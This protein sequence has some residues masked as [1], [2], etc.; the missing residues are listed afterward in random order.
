M[1]RRSE[2]DKDIAYLGM[3]GGFSSSQRGLKWAIPLSPGRIARIEGI[4][5][6]A[7]VSR[8]ISHA[9]LERLIGE[10]N[11]AATYIRDRFPKSTLRPIYRELPPP[12]LISA[13]ALSKFTQFGAV[14]DNVAVYPAQNSA[15]AI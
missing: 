7:I 4:L 1:G 6:V 9:S 3:I 14:V 5:T 15:R 10:L 2:V 8:P 13:I 11:S 12:S